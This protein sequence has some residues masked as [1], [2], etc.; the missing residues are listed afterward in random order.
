MNKSSLFL[1][2]TNTD[3]KFDDE[4]LGYLRSFLKAKGYKVNIG[5]IKGYAFDFS[6]ENTPAFTPPKESKPYEM[7]NA[8]D[9][10]CEDE[11]IPIFV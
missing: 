6:I 2:L 9:L 5:S 3:P 7:V 4:L 11:G 8:Y 10:D 1:T